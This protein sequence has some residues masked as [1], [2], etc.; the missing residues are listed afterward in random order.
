M[1]FKHVRL[2]KDQTLGIGSYGKVCK[3]KCDDLLCAAKV[4]HETLFDPTAHQLIAPQRE[5]RLPMRRFEQECDFL[6]TI[7]HPNI[8]QYLGVHRDPDTGLPVLLIELMDHSLTHFLESSLKPIP[9]HI[10]TSICHD[11][12]LALS[13]LHSNSIIHRDVSSNNVLMV[14]D[15]RAKVTDFGMASLRDLNRHDFT[16]IMCPG[17]DVYMPPEAVQDRPKYSE[18]L[19][20]FSFG[21]VILQILTLLFP[22]P[23]DRRRHIEIL[24]SESPTSTWSAEVAVPE[25]ERRSNHISIVCRN[26]PLLPLSLDCLK[27]SE[28][29]RPSAQELCVR[30]EALKESAEYCESVRAI[31]NTTPGLEQSSGHERVRESNT[32]VSP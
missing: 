10:Q 27:D 15:V 21:V 3:A 22:K 23:G 17:V 1:A 18:K 24:T 14:A 11:I 20:C 13:F 26:H 6:S 25:I 4:I 32:Q 30:I 7:K 12:A 31:Q 5:H 28:F 2:L 29:L 19:D 16:F 8:I 9:Y